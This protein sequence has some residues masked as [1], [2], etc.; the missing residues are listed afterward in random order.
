MKSIII[1]TTLLW[2]LQ[3]LG[4]DLKRHTEMPNDI[5]RPELKIENNDSTKFSSRWAFLNNQNVIADSLYGDIYSFWSK[6]TTPNAEEFAIL[7][8]FTLHNS[9]EALFEDLGYNLFISIRKGTKDGKLFDK[10]LNYLT[11]TERNELQIKMTSIMCVEIA[12]TNYTLSKFKKEFFFLANNAA[13]A[14]FTN[15]KENYAE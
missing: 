9:E 10:Y 15:C 2:Q 6:S 8:Y 3:A 5:I 4:C 13:I 7:F 12:S 14:E 11:P 1:L